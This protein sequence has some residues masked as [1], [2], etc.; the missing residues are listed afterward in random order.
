MNKKITKKQKMETL[1]FAHDV[2]R[3]RMKLSAAVQN[4]KMMQLMVF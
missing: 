1:S 2:I 3:E 4:P